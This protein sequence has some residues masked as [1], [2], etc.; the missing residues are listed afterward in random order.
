MATAEQ[1]LATVQPPLVLKP[2]SL[3]H[4]PQIFTDR[5]A[6]LNALRELFRTIAPEADNAGI[7]IETFLP[8]A[9]VAFSAFV[10]GNTA[11]P[12]LPAR[13]YDQLTTQTDTIDAPGM[14]AHTSTSEYAQRLRT[15]LDQRIMQPLLAALRSESIPYWGIL[16]IDCVIT[17][18]G[19]RVANLRCSMHDGEA[20]VVLP[21]LEDDILDIIRATAA[22]RLDQLPPLRWR[23]QASVG[24]ALVAQGYPH[25]FPTGSTLEGLA[26]IE[27]GT[28][29]FHDQTHNPL[30]MVYTPTVNRGPGAFSR[31]IMGNTNPSASLVTSGGHVLM[32]VALGDD[33]AGARARVLKN[34]QEI[35]FAGRTYRDDIGLHEFR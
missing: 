24:I 30:G 33:L 32:V 9:T 7:V 31:L 2:D 10:D 6:A 3:E 29:V 18:Q 19:P 23:N 11:L 12:L 27:P 22:R 15:Y 28:L 14:G 34:V 16:G 35:S 17:A 4:P 25:H 21:R 5:Y 1:Y 8:G 26:N 13:V 20:Q